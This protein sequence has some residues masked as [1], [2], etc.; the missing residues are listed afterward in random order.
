MG[1]VNQYRIK[2]Y[3]ADP[4]WVEYGKWLEFSRGLTLLTQEQVAAGLGITRRQWIRYTRGAPFPRKRI[5][6]LARVLGV[7]LAR[8]YMRAGY[9]VPD[10]GVDAD[11]YLRRIRESVFE[12]DLAEAMGTVYAFYYQAAQAEKKAKL[13]DTAMTHQDFIDAAFSANRLPGW[14]RVEFAE[15]L[16]A[17]EVSGQKQ[18]FPLKPEL[19]KK[20]RAMIKKALPEGLRVRVKIPKR[21]GVL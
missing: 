9:E 14:L 3:S 10:L 11:F 20:I 13:P 17:V 15:Y 6:D 1:R 8:A 5:P 12:D 18:D 7:P 4:R 2:L 21:R 19:R 16:L